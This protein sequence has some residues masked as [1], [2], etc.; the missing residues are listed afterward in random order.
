MKEGE[1]EDKEKILFKPFS[2]NGK[3]YKGFANMYKDVTL[4]DDTDL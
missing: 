1:K 4:L 2:I 3:E